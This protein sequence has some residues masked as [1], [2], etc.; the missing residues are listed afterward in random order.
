MCIVLA[1]TALGP[2]TTKCS[3]IIISNQFRSVMV[4][5]ILLW[6]FVKKKNN[7]NNPEKM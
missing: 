3:R 7:V 6:N 2:G 5:E 4:F 1:Q